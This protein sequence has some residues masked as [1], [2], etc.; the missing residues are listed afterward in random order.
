ME[1]NDYVEN[2]I[3]SLEHIEYLSYSKYMLTSSDFRNFLEK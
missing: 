1:N 3:K 2:Y